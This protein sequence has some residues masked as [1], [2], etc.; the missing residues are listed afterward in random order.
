MEIV[1]RNLNEYLKHL[2]R[3]IIFWTV[4]MILFS[5]FRY[6][7]L[8]EEIGITIKSV[9]NSFYSN[10]KTI[11]SYGFGGFLVGILYA[12]IEFYFDK[13]VSRRI[14]PLGVNILI[15]G[16]LIFISIIVISYLVTRLTISINNIPFNLSPYW[17]YQDQSFWPLL[18]YVLFSSYIFSMFI[19][20]SEKFGKGVFFKMLIGKYK[21]PK[22]EER[23]F[24]FLDLKSSTTIA[25]ILGHFKY[26]QLIQ[27]CF[28]DL[29]EVAPKYQ[30]EIYQYI[31]DEAVMC[32][33]YKQGISGNNCVN[34]FF[35]F[36]QKIHSKKSF[37]MK[38]YGIVPEF[39]AGIHGGVLMVAEVGV[40]KKELA[41]HGDVINTA[42]RIQEQCN[43]HDVSILISEKL[44]SD[45]SIAQYY[46][47][48]FMGTVLL[49]G[50]EK[51]INI[52]TLYPEKEIL[53]TTK[54][55]VSSIM[56]LFI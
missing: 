12:T 11:F 42:A 51:E 26:S 39:K 45:L 35:A 30:A 10:H 24:L 4:A 37:Y 23:I 41:Y 29:N 20:I 43:V 7:A 18:L 19:I 25:E 47:P 32:W 54:T 52:H 53:E 50:K 28:Y 34:L 17:W 33:P 6:Y 14:I 55:N 38:K 40:I 46:T 31:G 2:Y 8:D 5:I 27:D 44:L 1:S 15:Q 9:Y 3:S 49:K 48:K 21:Y 16:I 36:K 22:E 13:F 56:F